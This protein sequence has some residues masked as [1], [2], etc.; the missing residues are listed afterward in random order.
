MKTLNEIF[1]V[2]I[3]TLGYYCFFTL[4]N[5]TMMIFDIGFGY[6]LWLNVTF[7]LISAVLANIT[8]NKLNK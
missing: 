4:P 7:G 8:L 1:L 5:I 2:I 6:P 3:L